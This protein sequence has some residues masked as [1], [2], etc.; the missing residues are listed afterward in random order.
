MTKFSDE[1]LLTR[2]LNHLR[3]FHLPS[4]V[5]CR[6]LAQSNIFQKQTN[7]ITE[8]LQRA[9]PV[10]PWSYWK[11]SRF[12]SLDD[13]GTIE[14]RQMYAPSPLASLSETLV[15]A[16]MSRHEAFAPPRGVYS[17]LWP[18][19][20]TSAHTFRYY[21]PGYVSRNRVVAD[22]LLSRDS[23]FAVV[24]DIKKFY[25]TAKCNLAADRVRKVMSST[26]LP[27]AIYPIADALLDS[28][29]QLESNTIPIGPS[30]S[31]ILA[32][33]YLEP[34][35]SSMFSS[36]GEAYTRYVDDIVIV[37]PKSQVDVVIKHLNS[38]LS[39]L[40]LQLNELKLDV[41]DSD[42]WI[43]NAP[44]PSA[45]D[46]NDFEGWKT[47]LVFHL[48]QFP[49]E[50]DKMQE[51]F[52]REDFHLPLSRIRS[53]ARYNRL[54]KYIRSLFK[55]GFSLRLLFQMIYGDSLDNLIH[56][57]RFIR[58]RLWNQLDRL[59]NDP[60]P[61][62]VVVRQWKMQKYRYLLN[63][64]LY[65]VPYFELD[66]LKASAP[67][68]QELS[69]FHVLTAALL[70]RNVNKI[71]DYPGFA[72]QAFCALAREM[73]LVVSDV[74]DEL[75]STPH[76]VESLSY[77]SLYGLNKRLRGTLKQERF[78]LRF[79]LDE[80]ATHREM[81]DLSYL[82][83]IRTLQTGGKKG[84]VDHFIYSRFSDLEDVE[85]EALHLEGISVTG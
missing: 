5:G 85:L 34:F 41:V 57:G 6:S 77:L 75:V 1:L 10:R 16:E 15:L 13:S 3:H 4:Y 8:L 50:Y 78:Y 7:Y 79:C 42:T 36:Y 70:S 56:L 59:N 52:S 82:D 27:K 84:L 20:E 11:F 25:P 30:F 83:E 74:P 53:Q 76:R 40:G 18:A 14:Y 2:S 69:E 63:R 17:Y 24:T 39:D 64:L 62:G 48:D 31:H 51:A 21:R 35:D 54:S 46:W 73:R 37:S 45:P 22:L 49:E 60:I 26:N 29:P 12:K 9:A 61:K 44:L 66:R 71:I 33:Y 38:R 23:H 58:D 32:N 81:T 65:L 67:Q 43:N 72:V 55:S 80:A 19:P 28:M 47:R 68:V